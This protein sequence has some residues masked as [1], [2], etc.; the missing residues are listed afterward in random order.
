[1][2][3]KIVFIV[4]LALVSSAFLIK[5][6]T[7]KD[8]FANPLPPATCMDI[9]CPIYDGHSYE[10]DEYQGQQACCWTETTTNRGCQHGS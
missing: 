4:T 3:K 1:M 6:F 8:A 9:A 7:P 10:S 2:K 5:S